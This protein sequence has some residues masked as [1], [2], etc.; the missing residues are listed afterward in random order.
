M[1]IFDKKC[2]R[3]IAKAKAGREKGKLKDMPVGVY[4]WKRYLWPHAMHVKESE[5]KGDLR[6]MSEFGEAL[7]R[8][9]QFPLPVQ[10][11]ENRVHIQ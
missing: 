2:I 4:V 3:A 7:L 5:R 6:A 11:V 9:L 1:K 10:S 8:Q